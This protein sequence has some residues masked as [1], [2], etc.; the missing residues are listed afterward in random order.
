MPVN[1]PRLEDLDTTT[2]ITSMMRSAKPHSDDSLLRRENSSAD[3]A[4]DGN[5]SHDKGS[6]QITSLAEC[7]TDSLQA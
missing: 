5:G 4:S 6:R 7:G 1:P 2:A 3:I